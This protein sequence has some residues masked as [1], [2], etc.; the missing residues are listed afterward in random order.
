MNRD[1][2][3]LIKELTAQWFS[4]S[5]NYMLQLKYNSPLV[6]SDVCTYMF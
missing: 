6:H 3:Q 4:F 2:I 1:V 5:S